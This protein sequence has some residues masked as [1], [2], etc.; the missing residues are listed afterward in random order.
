MVFGWG[1]KKAKLE[2]A[3]PVVRKE[4]DVHISEIK[5]ILDDIRS[6]RTKTIIAEAK[7]FRKKIEIQL[8]DV[9]KITKD[10]ERDD[11]NVEDIDKH[12]EILV[13][14]GKKQVIEIIKK[15]TAEKLPEL[16][17]Y[18]DVE[19]LNDLVK[20]ILKRIGDI[21]G[22]QSRVIHIFAK[23]HAAKLKVHLSILN[24]DRGE[25]QILVDKYTKLIQDIELILEKIEAQ[26]QSSRTLL[27]TEK[28]ISELKQLKEKL[29]TEE[30]KIKQ[31]ISEFKTGENYS[32][33]LD[34]KKKLDLHLE[35]KHDIKNLIEIQFTKISRPL[36][37]Y[38]YVSSLDKPEKILLDTLVKNPIDTLTV[39]NRDVI[40][41][42]LSAV[43]KGVDGGSI[44]VK[45]SEK[46]ISSID[47]TIELLGDYI[48]KISKFN[49][50]KNKL[51]KELD[52]FN[53]D[54]LKKDEKFLSKTINEKI[55]ITSKIT[56][57]EGEISEIKEKLP[58][59]KMDM[60]IK[61]QSVSSTKYHIID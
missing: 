28:R 2:D 22:R 5:P 32:K 29:D 10:L 56:K 34:A 60:E 3:A 1:K 11:L 51:E 43:R 16:N 26:N 61:L 6:L 21:L 49:D 20:Q 55:E 27:E 31:K 37:R 13:V 50:D 24:S 53:N 4:K 17:S 45:D 30:E 33:Y 46:S 58:Q 14:R 8:N 7:T 35:K 57:L 23:K 12:L 48:S 38:E 39:K 9:L 42:I 47:E 44:S 41:K 15:E 52:V 25:I 36:G 40:I 19:E 54:T 59:I 18:R